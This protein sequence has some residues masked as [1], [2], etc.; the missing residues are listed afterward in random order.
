MVD[1]AVTS[2]VFHSCLKVAKLCKLLT[3]KMLVT[4]SSFATAG[5][6]R[7]LSVSM[8]NIFSLFLE[9]SDVYRVR[10]YH[11]YLGFNVI[12]SWVIQC[13]IVSGLYFVK[14]SE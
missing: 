7:P 12:I 8:M 10:L 4:E 1:E 13:N 11:A 3:D 9:L 5:R 2:C 14:E 6:Y